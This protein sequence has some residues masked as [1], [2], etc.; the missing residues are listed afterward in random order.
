MLLFTS[1]ILAQ[2]PYPQDFFRSP[3]DIPLQLSGNF[4]E[5]RSNHFHA[6]FDFRT[7]QKEGLN[8]Y[9]AADG[10][11][12]RIKIST[13]GYGKA[14]YIDHPNGYTTVYGHLQRGVGA[15]ENFIKAQQYKEEK[16][17]IEVFLKPGELVVKK[18][19]LIALSGN[20]GG[21]GGPH[22]H[23]EIRE[24][25]S[26]KVLNPLLFGFN[27][28]IID[29][30]KPVITD[31][32][33]YPIDDD[34]TANESKQPI[35][36]GLSQQ[37][38]GNYISSKVFASGRIG[39]GISSYDSNNY[40]S[41]KN[42]TYKTETYLNGNLAFGYQFDT[43]A[44]DESRYINALID[45]P[46][47]KR[48]SQRVQRL[49]M[50]QPFPLS[51]IRTD[52]G[53]GI[54]TVEPNKMQM[55]RIEVSDF[56]N[57]KS[58]ISVPIEYSAAVAK[59]TSA[60]KATSYFVKSAK[61]HNFEKDNFSVFIPANTFY[62]DTY[63]DFDAKNGEYLI[64]NDYIAA[65]NNFTV[66]IKD[67]SI[68]ASL[69]DKTFIASVDGKR[70][71]YNATKRKGNE[72]TSYTKNMGRFKLAN[73][74]IAPRIRFVKAI[75]GKWI[76]SDKVLEFAISDN[77]AGI[78]D[79]DAYVNGNWILFEWDYKSGKITYNFAD[80]KTVE[81][82]NEL[83]IVVSDNVGNSAIFETHFFRK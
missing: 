4:G 38:D 26:E 52:E 71:G 40:S 70:V 74:T 64:G 41:N 57:N 6:G 48:F 68:P 43:F 10:Y 36:V 72:F 27:S 49:F 60:I 20:T 58:V 75:E 79:F 76:S 67:D 81:G 12:S 14:I 16:F 17:D 46:R 66:T 83:K 13:Y 61:D 59:N 28:I 30:K 31:L 82:R 23:F 3:L 42:G 62:E 45:Y 21:S 56:N 39:F 25:A 9:A 53:N 29:T 18:G 7:Q 24:T 47:Y 77:L 69:I 73:D 50:K 54:L 15:I 55:Y 5:L 51:I 35:V 34:A 1:G 11:V 44:F 2:N 78:K 65:H 19:D 32:I 22:L 8:V 37:P 33:V 63:V 80:G